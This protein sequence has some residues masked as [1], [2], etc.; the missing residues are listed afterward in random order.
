[1]AFDDG[2]VMERL[3]NDQPLITAVIAS[4]TQRAPEILQDLE[5]ALLAQDAERAARHLHSLLGSSA[6]VS[7]NGVNA[8]VSSMGQWLRAGDPAQVRRMLPQL[9][10]KLESF[11]L[12]AAAAGF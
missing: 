6:A 7:A 5:A 10:H 9:A 8:L 11:A 1:M 4:F 3:G 2:S 12:A